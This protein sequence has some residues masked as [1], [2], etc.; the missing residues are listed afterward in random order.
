MRKLQEKTFKIVFFSSVFLWIFAIFGFYY[1]SSFLDVG[2]LTCFYNHASQF[3]ITIYEAAGVL[4]NIHLSLFCFF[5]AV[6]VV[7]LYA[8]DVKEDPHEKGFFRF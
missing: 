4:S 7:S 1:C 5:F 6:T 8:V 3:E 2:C